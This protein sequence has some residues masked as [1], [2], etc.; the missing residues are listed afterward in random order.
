V[1]LDESSEGEC[2]DDCKTDTSDPE[3]WNIYVDE[4]KNP[5]EDYYTGYEVPEK[6]ER[7]QTTKVPSER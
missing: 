7:S 4:S 6:I 1:T 3:F 5:D 2:T